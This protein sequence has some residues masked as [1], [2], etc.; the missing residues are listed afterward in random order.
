MKAVIKTI[1]A[2]A[3]IFTAHSAWAE[4]P[5]SV[6]RTITSQGLQLE[7]I[8]KQEPL[9]EDTIPFDTSEVAYFYL[10]QSNDFAG[11][12]DIRPFVKPEKELEEETFASQHIMHQFTNA[13]SR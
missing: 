9:V 6:F 5:V 3:L 7:I 1:V 12:I 4:Y 10:N 11:L 8:S 13:G 2:A